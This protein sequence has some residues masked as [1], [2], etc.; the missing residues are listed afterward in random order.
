MTRVLGLVTCFNRKEKT[1]KALNNLIQGNPN[2]QFTFI[3]VDDGSTDGTKEAVEQIP[4]VQVI[5][6]VGNLFYSGGMRVAIDAAKRL[7][8]SYDYCLLFNDDVEFWEE[9]LEK[10][11]ERET[12]TI[13]IG[14]T[15]EN[16]GSLSYGGVIKTSKWRPKT[17]IIMAD[18]PE[19]RVCDTFN[20]NCVLIPWEIFMELEN[21]D[22]AYTHSI[23]DFDYGFAAKKKGYCI[24]VSNEYVGVCPDN[25]VNSNSNW[26]NV[27]LPR[28][29]RIQLKESKKGLPFA[30]Y[31]H[32][33]NKNY[34]FLTAVLY[35]A[36]P[37]IRILLK[38]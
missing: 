18:S 5:S 7:Q 8:E 33:L 22:D 27:E 35:S 10:L 31:F 30:E 25:P 12:S 28:K 38:K 9:A 34:N 11:C 29:R 3:V 37:Y 19:G 17:E 21:I 1:V 24:K 13:W 32:Y 23:G 2:L 16:D 4:G 36:M 14:P 15:C 20:A 26:R 6:G